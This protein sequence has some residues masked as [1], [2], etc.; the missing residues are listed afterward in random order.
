MDVHTGRI[1]DGVI[2]IDGATELPEGAAVQVLVGDPQ[3]SVHVSEG[4]SDEI[5]AGLLQAESGELLDA[6]RF[7]HELRKL[8]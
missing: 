4:E 2:V 5:R 1:V 7:L 8:G 6:R 3:L